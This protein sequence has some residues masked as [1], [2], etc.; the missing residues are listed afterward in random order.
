LTC[1]TVPR[2]V[3]P[4]KKYGLIVLSDDHRLSRQRSS[5]VNFL[6]ALEQ[7]AKRIEVG[8]L[9]TLLSDRADTHLRLRPGTSGALALGMAHVII[10][11]GLFDREFVENWTPGF[12]EYCSYVREFAPET[13]ERITGIAKDKII[14]AAGLYATTKPAAVTTSSNTTVHHTNGVQ[15]HR[16][17]DAEG[18]FF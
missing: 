6:N 5:N 9:K 3:A 1:R 17:R 15:N 18:R 13:T 7:G 8:P 4:A 2:I 11:E 16:L 14:K 12:N 10:E